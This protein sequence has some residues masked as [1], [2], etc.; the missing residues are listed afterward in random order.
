M[1]VRA[2]NLKGGGGFLNN[3][4]GTITSYKFME[5]FDGKPV[6]YADGQFRRLFMRFEAK[7]DGATEAVGQTLDCGGS[8]ELAISKDGLSVTPDDAFWKTKNGS[9]FLLTLQEPTAGGAGFPS[10]RLPEAGEPVNLTPIVGTRVRFGQEKDEEKAKYEVKQGR[11]GKRKA[12]NG[13]EYDF[14]RTIIQAVLTLPGTN[15][16]TTAPTT[17][18]AAGGEANTIAVAIFKELISEADNGTLLKEA[19]ADGFTRKAMKRGLSNEVREAV[20][21]LILSAEFQ[22]SQQGWVTEDGMFAIPVTA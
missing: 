1:G 15:G 4:D 8:T 5:S 2:E 19:V 21:K 12:D 22:G 17:K 3:V 7:V 13:R 11:T 6:Q 9:R 20:K 10:E 14:T 18:A 16:G